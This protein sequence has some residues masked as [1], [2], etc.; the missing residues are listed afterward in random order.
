MTHDTRDD[1]RPDQGRVGE[2]EG[3]GWTLATF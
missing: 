3:C 2:I 1:P